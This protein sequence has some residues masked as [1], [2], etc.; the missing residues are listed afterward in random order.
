MKNIAL[1]GRGMRI[2]LWEKLVIL[3]LLGSLAFSWKLFLVELSTLV[4]WFAVAVYFDESEKV[5]PLHKG[6]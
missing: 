3:A 5:Y 4:L 6:R 1:K 2:A